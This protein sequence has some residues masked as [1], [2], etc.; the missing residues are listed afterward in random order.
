[1]D[2]AEDEISRIA[3]QLAEI[4]ERLADVALERLRA[5]A[6]DPDHPDAAEQARVERRIT[7][8]RRS[9][10]KAVSLLEGPVGAED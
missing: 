4:G 7:R 2:H 8:A 9:V 6:L 5:A 10:E 1:V 3:A